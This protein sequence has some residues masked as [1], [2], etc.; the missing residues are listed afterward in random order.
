MWHLT[1]ALLGFLLDTYLGTTILT[2]TS[3]RSGLLH[4][5]SIRTSENRYF[6][7]WATLRFRVTKIVCCLSSDSYLIAIL[8]QLW[9]LS[10]MKNSVE[11]YLRMKPVKIHQPGYKHKNRT[12]CEQQIETF[13]MLLLQP[14]LHVLFM[15]LSSF[16]SSDLNS[17]QGLRSS[18]FHAR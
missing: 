8:P 15:L 16:W 13:F 12:I 17:N 4:D 2:L 7:T 6:S 3:L 14:H 11:V 1:K 9:R 10:V 18:V 5:S